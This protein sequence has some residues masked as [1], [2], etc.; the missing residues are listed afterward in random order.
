M[1]HFFCQAD[2]LPVSNSPLQLESYFRE[3]KASGLIEKQINAD[4]SAVLIV[5]SGSPCWAYALENGESSPILLA[6]F[7]SSTEEAC[8][9][10]AIKLPDVA[11]RLIWLALESQVKNKYLV[12][13]EAAWKKQLSQWKQDQWNGLIEITAKTLHGFALF[14][15]GE[16]QKP[17]IIFSTPQGFI[18]NFPQ[19]ENVEDAVWEVTTYAHIASTQAYQC[20]ILRQGAVHWSYQILSHYREIVGQKLLQLMDRE[21]NRQIQ[22]WQWNISLNENVMVDTH[23]FSHLH[24]AAHAYRA[25]F[26]EMGMQ[27]D[28]V[29][30]SNLTQRILSETFGKIHPDERS[31]LQSQR[32]IPAAISE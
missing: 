11:G 20:A 29:I 19:M 7:S 15:Q 5:V 17:E 23:F 4:R 28:F 30:G 24:D 21:L 6:E 8:H 26:M 9:L 16:L 25:L 27:M 1:K 14:W 3:Q 31:V 13:N 2:D 12:D 32:L 18:T 22:P 10:R